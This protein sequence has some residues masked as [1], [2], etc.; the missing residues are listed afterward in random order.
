MRLQLRSLLNL[1]SPVWPQQAAM[2]VGYI[3]PLALL[4]LSVVLALLG[5]YQGAGVSFVAYLLAHFP[6]RG[7]TVLA[8][9][10]VVIKPSAQYPQGAIMDVM[11]ALNE[12]LIQISD[13]S[14][15]EFRDIKGKLKRMRDHVLYHFFRLKVATAW[16]KGN[17]DLFQD[18]IG[19]QVTVPNDAATQYTQDYSDTN[20]KSSGGT[21]TKGTS[22]VVQSIQAP[23]DIPA[24][25]DTTALLNGEAID[26]TPQA[27][28]AVGVGPAALCAALRDNVALHFEVDNVTFEEGPLKFFPSDFSLTGATNGISDGYASNGVKGRYLSR[29][30]HIES[31][32]PFVVHLTV[33][34]AIT[35]SRSC[36]IG[37]ALVGVIYQPVVG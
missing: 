28:P 16:A 22:M 29:V 19:K 6:E 18:G 8:S 31:Q 11:Q 15:N 3:F 30:R 20:M 36:R 23:I 25:L 10:S 34:N 24:S 2:L 13:L 5:S 35:I 17:L 9:G 14:Q 26:P 1:R 21:F 4:A 7:R 12:G 32:Q 27:Q 37:V 33:E